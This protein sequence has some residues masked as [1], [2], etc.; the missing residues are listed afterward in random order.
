M[1]ETVQ[2]DTLLSVFRAN[3]RSRRLELGFSQTTLAER[4]G[5]DQSYI[6]DL[7]QGKKRPLIDSLAGLAEALD[8]TPSA[9]LSTAVSVPE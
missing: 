8:T 6:S 4:A 7:E 9:L 2:P 5:V 3:L 1:N